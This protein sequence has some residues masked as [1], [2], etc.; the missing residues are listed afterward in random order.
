MR[1]ENGVAKAKLPL[2]GDIGIAPKLV[3][4]VKVFACFGKSCDNVFV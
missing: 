4:R 2:Q 1:D 3:E